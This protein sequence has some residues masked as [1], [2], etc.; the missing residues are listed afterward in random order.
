MAELN[1]EMQEKVQKLSMIEQQMTSF[2]SQKQTFQAQLMEIDSAL[3]ELE[4]TDKAY[5]IIGN[6]MVA[7]DK[8][9]LKLDLTHKRETAELRLKSLENQEEKLRSKAAELQNEVLKHIKEK[10]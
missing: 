2:L 8:P 10:Q 3:E 7:S 6:V 5:R 4:K 9:A 1:A